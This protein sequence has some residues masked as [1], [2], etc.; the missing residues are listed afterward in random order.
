MKLIFSQES[1][2]PY[3]RI[4]DLGYF[5][6]KGSSGLNSIK[7]SIMWSFRCKY[8]WQKT[9]LGMCGKRARKAKPLFYETF[10]PAI[11][12]LFMG[13]LMS[14]DDDVPSL[15]GLKGFIV[16]SIIPIARKR[17]NKELLPLRCLS[18]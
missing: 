1:F 13:P 3:E 12:S 17:R 18:F 15:G 16:S 2:S 11:F 9:V 8:K 5:G 7:S 6:R 14:Y 4:V 10:I